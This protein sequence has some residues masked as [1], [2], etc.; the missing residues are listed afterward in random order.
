MFGKS[1]NGDKPN[2]H[3]LSR[4][5]M[6]A[7]S[8]WTRYISWPVRNEL[9]HSTDMTIRHG[10]ADVRDIH[11]PNLASLHGHTGNSKRKLLH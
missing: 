7:N 8:C 6:S 11:N 5:S 4:G 10:P 3:R 2:E 9:S 1:Q